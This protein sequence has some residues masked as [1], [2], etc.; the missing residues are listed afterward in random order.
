L[1]GE[2]DQFRVAAYGAITTR[3]RANFFGSGVWGNDRAVAN[4]G[5]GQL[6]RKQC[7]DGDI[8]KGVEGRLEFHDSGGAGFNDFQK[9]S[10]GL[11]SPASAERPTFSGNQ[12]PLSLGIFQPNVHPRGVRGKRPDPSCGRI[13]P[14]GVH[15]ISNRAK[16]SRFRATP[17]SW[18]PIPE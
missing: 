1:A 3:K 7:A 12:T 13:I 15:P 11:D 9:S 18:R 10:Q 2:A 6:R 16:L 4:R 17:A 14:G 8:K 5:L